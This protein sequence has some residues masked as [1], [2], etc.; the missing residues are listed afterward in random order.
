MNALVVPVLAV[1]LPMVEQAPAPED[2]KPGWIG[3]G[4]VVALFVITLLLWTN[5]KKQIRKIDFDEDAPGTPSSPAPTDPADG[6]A[7]RER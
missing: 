2:I 7:P 4:F 6:P 1:V 3:L 5:M